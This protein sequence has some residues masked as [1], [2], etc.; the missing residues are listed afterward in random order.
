MSGQPHVF[1]DGPLAEALRATMSIP[2][3]FTPIRVGDHVYTDGGIVNNLPTDVVR[4]MGADIVIAVHLRQRELG[5]AEITS[6]FQIL[7]R[8]LDLPI[9]A[10]EARGL[11]AADVVVSVDVSK[12]SAMDYG[13][14]DA[15]IA[16]GRE[17]ATAGGA[18]AAAVRPGGGRLGG[19]PAGAR[20]RGSDT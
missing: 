17:A 9:S 11:A 6:M 14:G 18:R 8:T 5:A 12:L 13:N 2:G 16:K 10:N 15:F 3:F 7:G 19:A 20:G 1:S 4:Q